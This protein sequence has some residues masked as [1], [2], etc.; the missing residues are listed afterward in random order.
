VLTQT[1]TTVWLDGALLDDH[2]VTVHALTHALH[3]GSA[4]FEG[5]RVY[6]TPRG[7]AI[8]R[9]RDHVERLIAGAGVYGMKLAYDADALCD[10]I[11]STVRASGLDAA[12]VRPLAFYAGDSI[13]LNPSMWCPTSVMI[14]VFPFEGLLPPTGD[15]LV[16]RAAISPVLKTPSRALPSTVKGS[17]HYMNSIRALMEAQARGFDEAILLNDRGEVAEGS[18]ENIFILRNGTL[19][20]NDVDADILPGFTRASILELAHA[21]GIVT[22]VR[23]ITVDDLRGAGEAFFTGTAAEVVPI[24]QIEDRVFGGE[25][26]MTRWLRTTYH[27][28]V[29]GKIAGPRD[30]LTA[31]S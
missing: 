14:A 10:A 16:F 8:F 13:R 18:G 19:V 22:Q 23:P 9:L 5:I 4:V 6:P 12:Y 24:V 15:V 28:V 3:Y 27:D 30:W 31:A 21:Q 29:R 17:G 7:P 26:A 1:A 20:T 11:R 25:G 2:H